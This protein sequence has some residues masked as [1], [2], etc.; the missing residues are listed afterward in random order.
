[1][2]TRAAEQPDGV[3]E[4][5]A[6]RRQVHAAAILLPEFPCDRRFFASVP[7]PMREDE[8]FRIERISLD[9]AER[10][11][12]FEDFPPEHFDPCLRVPDPEAEQRPDEQFIRATQ[13][14]P[15]WG[16]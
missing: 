9:E 11:H 6:D 3:P 15:L 16:V 4:H 10:E 8:E 5:P 2:T 1:D 12:A 7:E 13:E 14:P